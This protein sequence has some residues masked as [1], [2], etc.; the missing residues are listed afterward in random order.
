MMTA[1][2]LQN[3][4]SIMYGFDSALSLTVIQ[5]AWSPGGGRDALLAFRDAIFACDPFLL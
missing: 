2:L 5:V 4:D 3:I 1:R